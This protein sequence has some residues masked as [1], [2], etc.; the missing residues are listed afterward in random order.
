MA[1]YIITDTYDKAD[2]KFGSGCGNVGLIDCHYVFGD[3]LEKVLVDFLPLI[4]TDFEN[5]REIRDIV[6][7]L[8]AFNDF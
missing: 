6:N 3:L 2:G 8:R 1:L 4:I 7:N 5:W